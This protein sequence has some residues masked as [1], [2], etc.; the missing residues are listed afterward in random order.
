MACSSLSPPSC[1]PP[2]VPGICNLA[3]NETYHLPP[4]AMMEAIE[5]ELV[6]LE[7][8]VKVV[9]E[10]SSCAKDIFG[11]ACSH[12]FRPCAKLERRPLC[13]RDC[14]GITEETCRSEWTRALGFMGE[15]NS[16]NST[17][18]IFQHL[19]VHLK[20]FDC[21]LAGDPSNNVSN[22][23]CVN[24]SS[25]TTS[26]TGKFVLYIVSCSIFTVHRVSLVGSV[27]KDEG[28]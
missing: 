2:D 27:V 24:L 20:G 12:I 6:A 7:Q 10:S 15:V 5:Q 22:V 23:S 28:V 21:S 13:E 14:K 19:W 11:L 3:M 4:L 26:S 17:S 18:N 16:D 1:R 8:L 25:I 9:M